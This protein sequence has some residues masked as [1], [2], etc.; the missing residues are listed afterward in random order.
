MHQASQ[1]NTPRSSA[2]Q[3]FTALLNALKALVETKSSLGSED[4][5]KAAIRLMLG[6]LNHTNPILRCAAGE[7]LGRMAQVVGDG[8]FVAEM[9]QHMFD[10]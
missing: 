9:A 5:R 4:V 7:A 6:S 1:S 10:K 2:D 8:R 3:Y